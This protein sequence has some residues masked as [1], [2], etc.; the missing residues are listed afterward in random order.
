MSRG[1]QRCR[2]DSNH[3]AVVEALA[4]L[5]GILLQ[6]LAI[7]GAGCPDLLVGYRGEWAL[8]EVKD[9]DKPPSARALTDPEKGWHKRARAA[10]CE[11]VIADSPEDAVLAVMRMGAKQK[12]VGD[13]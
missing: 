1:I 12:G 9:G 11:V 8:M 10:G 5:P 6:S 7:V 13:E 2:L 3:G 4:T